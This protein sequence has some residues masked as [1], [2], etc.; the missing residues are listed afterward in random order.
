MSIQTMTHLGECLDSAFDTQIFGNANDNI[1]K[2]IR[3]TEEIIRERYQQKIDIDWEKECKLEY[4]KHKYKNIYESFQQ[5]E[6][7]NGKSPVSKN[8]LRL[9]EEILVCVDSM[10]LLSY[11]CQHGVTYFDAEGNILK[12]CRLYNQNIRELWLKNGVNVPRHFANQ[13]EDC[14]I[15]T[16]SNWLHTPKP[17]C[18]LEKPVIPKDTLVEEMY[19]RLS[20]Y[21]RKD[22]CGKDLMDKIKEL[23][24]LL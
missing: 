4:E 17:C 15:T 23:R 9:N 1:L 12:A 14:V 13:G 5:F 18:L 19:D 3:A 16:E 24:A 7:K 2:E 11:P 21:Q 10:C 8:Y 20:D 6:E 22:V